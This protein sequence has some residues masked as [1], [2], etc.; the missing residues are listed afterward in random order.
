MNVSAVVGFIVALLTVV[1]SATGAYIY[2][3]TKHA[4]EI[5]HQTLR[6][7]FEATVAGIDLRFLQNQ[8]MSLESRGLCDTPQYSKLCEHLRRQIRQQSK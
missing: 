3:D 4:Q 5:D 2:L 6:K 1:G 7:N 8:L